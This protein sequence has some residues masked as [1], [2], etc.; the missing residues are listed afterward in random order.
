MNRLIIGLGTIA[1]LG[2]S[3]L[4]V[5]ANGSIA[6]SM[7]RD[8][9]LAAKRKEAQVKK[10]TVVA[11]ESPAPPVTRPRADNPRPVR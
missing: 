9:W 8:H 11:Q 7:A 3:D 6:A 2:F 5:A 10:P 1:C 4:A